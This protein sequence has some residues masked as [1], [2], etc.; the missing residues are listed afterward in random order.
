MGIPSIALKHSL[1]ATGS[2]AMPSYQYHHARG[3]YEI[4]GVQYDGRFLACLLFGSAAWSCHD[5]DA[6]IGWSKQSRKMNLQEMTNNR[7]LIV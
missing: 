3:E 1:S 7:R 2:R 4:Y 5:R 6:Y